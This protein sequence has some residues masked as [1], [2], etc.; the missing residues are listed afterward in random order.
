ML[1]AANTQVHQPHHPL[2][3]LQASEIDLLDDAIPTGCS[4]RLAIGD[5][6][7]VRLVSRRSAGSRELLERPVDLQPRWNVSQSC[8]S[9]GSDSP[10]NRRKRHSVTPDGIE[11][12]VA[13]KLEQMAFSLDENPFEASL[14]QMSDSGVPSIEPFGI[15]LIQ[16][17][18]SAREADLRRFHREGGSDSS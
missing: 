6:S 1:P 8:R 11:N 17:L 15:L 10:D 14:K 13:E 16:A 12:E 5:K 2:A 4:R 3:E 18:D 9:R 7:P